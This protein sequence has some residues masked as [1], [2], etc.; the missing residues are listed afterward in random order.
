M[1]TTQQ[2]LS[3]SDIKDNII[4][5][6]DGGGALVLQISAVNFRL[7][8][9][10]E[11]IAIISSFAQ[12]LNSLSFSIQILIFSERLNIN[13]YLVLLDKAQKLQS[14]PMLSNMIINY[15]QFIQNTIKENEVLDKKF[16]LVIPLFNL[17][18]GLAP[19]RVILQQKI[20]TILLPRRD[21]IIRQLS[22]VGLA[23]IQLNTNELIE[24]FYD[25]YNG[26]FVE[27]MASKPISADT[28]Q[29]QLN[30]P[31]E[32]VKTSTYKSQVVDQPQAPL[33]PSP[34]TT[35]SSRTHPF[36]V[37]ELDENT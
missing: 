16:Y 21:Q 18:L 8:S 12:M 22:R 17:E 11:Q 1:S 32:A 23:A 13:S 35:Q 37:E 20:K 9:E 25:I 19:T 6:K 33:Q 4:L 24:L 26:Q 15:R 7:L 36:V 5:L 27:S 2:H 29:V 30:Q 31:Q 28:M 14:N 10:R 3:I 34:A